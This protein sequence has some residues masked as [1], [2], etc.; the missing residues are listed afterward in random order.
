MSAIYHSFFTLNSTAQSTNT[1]NVSL[2]IRRR[3]R[4]LIFAIGNSVTRFGEKLSLTEIFWMAYFE[5]DK[6]LCLLC[7]FYATGQIFIAVNGQR[8]NNIAIW[9]HWLASSAN[10]LRVPYHLSTSGHY[11]RQKYLTLL[12]NGEYLL[13]FRFFMHQCW[14]IFRLFIYDCPFSLSIKWHLIVLITLQTTRWR[15]CSWGGFEPGAT[16]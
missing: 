8:M 7:Y 5:F 2:Q 11:L 1:K 6:R 4:Y 10:S 9:S 3:L 14:Y 13:N 12:V 15:C 16:W